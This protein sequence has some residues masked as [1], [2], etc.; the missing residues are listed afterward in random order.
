MRDRPT[1]GV[2]AAHEITCV[3]KTDRTGVHE[4]I[5]TIGGID[6]ADGKRWKLSQ[7]EAIMAIETGKASFHVANG[8]K[9]LPVV[10]G[11]TSWGHKYLK[12]AHD[13][14]QPNGLL[15]LPECPYF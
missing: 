12:S 5:Q 7:G 4:K 3:R 9:P 2:M 6:P 14:E 1:I 10:V 11:I 13:R 15:N 8:G